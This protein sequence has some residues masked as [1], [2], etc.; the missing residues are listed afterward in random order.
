MRSV[1]NCIV[2][3]YEHTQHDLHVFTEYV[4]ST[5]CILHVHR[6]DTL[7]DGWDPL[8][9]YAFSPQYNFFTLIDV[10]PSSTPKLQKRIYLDMPLEP[11][12]EVVTYPSYVR[13][14]DVDPPYEKI[15]VDEF[16]QRFQAHLVTLPSSF[17]A[18]GITPEKTYIYSEKYILYHEI[19]PTMRF[20]I[21]V[22][23]KHKTPNLYFVI[24]ACDGFPENTQYSIRTKPI[25]IDPEKYRNRFGLD[26]ACEPNEFEQL[27]DKAWILCQNNHK[28]YAFTKPL[29]DHH[30]FVLNEYREFRWLHQGLSF[31]CKIP[32][33]VFASTKSRSSNANFKQTPLVDGVPNTEITQRELFYKLFSYHEN[34]Y[35][36]E[37]G[38]MQPNFVPREEQVYYK[39]ILD[40]DGL[41]STWDSFAWKLRSGS[42]LFRVK[43]VWNQW[44]FDHFKE[45]IHYISIEEDFSDLLEKYEWCE[46]HPDECKQ[47]IYNACQLFEIYRLYHAEQYVLNEVLEL[48]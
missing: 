17:Y 32:K 27:H 13:G 16:N 8:R 14:H 40:M 15:T 6:L 35:A 12:T 30:Y 2:D 11:D 4:N 48:M 5:E 20:L 24:C 38:W 36:V 26:Y 47:I 25:S 34:V 1:R 33:M 23:R 45:G 31:D 18:I 44:F 22:I 7:T 46:Q 42:V 19:A 41:A 28:D 3:V 21:H 29:P 10:E 37:S 9:V 39:Y 43:G